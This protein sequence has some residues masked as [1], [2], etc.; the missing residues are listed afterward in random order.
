MSRIS[1][2]DRAASVAWRRSTQGVA[3][4]ALVVYA[5]DWRLD[6]SRWQR[7]A[8]WIAHGGA[9]PA[10]S[11]LAPWAVGALAVLAVWMMIW[12]ARIKQMREAT[13][14][15]ETRRGAEV[16]GE[17]LAKLLDEED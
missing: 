14:H 4:V 12:V 1:E 16:G 7:I 13:T 2:T 9:F 10:W 17:D 8:E 15:Q 3:A 6:D 5:A 11:I